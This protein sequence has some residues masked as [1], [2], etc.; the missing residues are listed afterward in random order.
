MLKSL[1]CERKSNKKNAGLP[2]RRGERK[3]SW[4]V[5]EVEGLIDAL[6]DLEAL[7]IS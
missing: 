7:K 3:K 5:G 2:S 1:V 4:K 6:L